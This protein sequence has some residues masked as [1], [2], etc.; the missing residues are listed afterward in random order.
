M[1]S[2]Q[3]S[4]FAQDCQIGSESDW[5]NVSLK[6]LNEDILDSLEKNGYQAIGENFIDTEKR[7]RKL[8]H[9]TETELKKIKIDAAR[10]KSCLVFVDTSYYYD[11]EKLFYV[12]YIKI[13]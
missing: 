6:I 4:A 11:N 3:L 8:K 7:I 10:S 2:I 5:E 1:F 12:W 9:L 13:K